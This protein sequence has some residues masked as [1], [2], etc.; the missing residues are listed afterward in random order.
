LLV[1]MC[2]EIDKSIFV[3]SETTFFPFVESGLELGMDPATARAIVDWPGP[4]SRK[5][6]QQLLGLLNFDRRFI[7]S[8]SGIVSPIRIYYDMIGNFYGEKHRRKPF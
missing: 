8:F 4:T 6:V 2:I 5:E 3:G 7:H 1:N